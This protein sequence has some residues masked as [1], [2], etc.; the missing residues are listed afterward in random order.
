MDGL[1]QKIDEV[2]TPEDMSAILNSYF[3]G[4]EDY[5]I[6]ERGDVGSWIRLA[7][8]RG[9]SS[10]FESF[11]RTSFDPKAR[12]Q[13]FGLY[14]PAEI[15]HRAIGCMLKQGV[16]RLDNVR[17]CVG[18]FF[19]LLLDLPAPALPNG[20]KWTIIEGASYANVFKSKDRTAWNNGAW[21]YPRAV[22]FLDIAEYRLPVLKGFILSV[23]S[24]TNSTV[25]LIYQ[26]IRRWY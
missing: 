2:I 13:D 19:M 16:E 6:N 23:G 4:L 14:L 25:S 5:T 7:C 9:I 24:R 17:Q 3:T 11:I 21:L 20:N 18:E 10:V 15:Y 1:T 12:L 22:H 26:Y 8:L